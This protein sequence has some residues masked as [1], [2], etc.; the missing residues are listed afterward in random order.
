M[1][2]P[3]DFEGIK[4][5]ALRSARSLLPE[6][7]TGG[8]FEGDEYVVRN[9][10]RDDKTPGSFKIN[11]RTGFWKDF[12]TG[13]GGN[14]L[15]SLVHY[16]DGISQ[17]EAARLFAEKLGIS[18][19]KTN[20]SKGH[21]KEPSP[22]TFSWGEEG[23]RIGRDEVRRHYY[24]NHDTPKLKVKIKK[25]GASKDSWVTCYR[26]IRDGV[27][28]GWQWKKPDDFRVVPYFG[29]TRDPKRSY[30]PE[31][32][33]DADTLDG[34]GLSAF[35]F[36]GVGDGLPPGIEKY[37]ERLKDRQL[38]IPV[39]NDETGRDHAQKKAAL[40]HA[41]GVTH[42]RIFDPKAVWP[43]CP[44]GG[45]VS[46]WFERGG[47]TREKLLEIIDAL[48]DW[49]P[50]D[51]DSESENTDDASPSWDNPDLSL[52]DDRRGE[53]PPFPLNVLSA[54]WQE[55][56]TNAAHGAGTTVDHVLVPL[57]GVASSLVGT[58]R[59]LQ[60][61]TS[62]TQPFTLWIAIVGNSGTGKTPGLNVSQRTLAR[63][64]RNR[65]HLIG[66]L[67]R[68]HETKIENAKVAR[69]QW[70]EKV[71]EAVDAG[72]KVPD[73]PPEAEVPEP[74]EAPRL[75]LSNVTIEK[76]A[77]L[78]QARPQGMLVT[79]DELAG[80]FLNLSRYSGGTDR[81]FWLE[82][83]NGEAY[84]VERMGRPPVDIE[85]LLVG[86]A[87]GLQPD[88]LAR[89]FD[90]DADG[91]YA[92]VLFSWPAE[93]PYRPLTDVVHEM[94]PELE[95]VF[96]RL[97]DLAESEEGKL[98]VRNVT[99]TNDARDVFEAFRRLVHSKKDGLDGRER[100]WWVKT[101]AHVLRLAGTLAYLDWA[102]ETVGTTM[103]E[104]GRIETRFVTAA[105]R[106]VSEYFWPHARAALRQI[107]LT[108]RHTKA[109][110]VLRWLRAERSPGSE[111][112]LKDIR[113]DAL[114]QSLDAEATTKLIE[115]LV[116]AGWLRRVPIE[117]DGRGR[118]PHR[119]SINP[120]LW[121]AENADNA[122]NS[123]FSSGAPTAQ[124]EVSFSALPAFSAPTQ[125][126]DGDHDRKEATWT[127]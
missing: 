54:S 4:V 95:N 7:L 49:Q 83:W 109:R 116:Q 55:W 127:V 111:L 76:L 44:D 47:G 15:I 60:A 68:A 50:T 126:I 62:W 78:L 56:A 113:R 118:T 124:P 30:W 93:A 125:D 10:R 88:K 117:K 40:A 34:P 112:S 48:P 64:E 45:D 12:A 123:P 98:I 23:P 72:R 105:V 74:F 77:V 9:P 17:G 103:P 66:K 96:I 110:K 2:Q 67:R 22:Q 99:L 36:G 61:S 32:E 65:R 29:K 33:K 18:T 8:K 73:M 3:I 53:L 63:V 58:A 91:L 42:I 28:I 35:T 90:G 107:G 71:K 59:R 115:A 24:P 104:P 97:I 94:D 75:F 6:L 37:L 38:V 26:A 52:L 108:E 106:L 27:P 92:R 57:F 85:H 86:L 82:A 69:K 121:G 84:R 19:Y 16:V 1:T 102:R 101:P 46:D 5:A 81:E 89:S 70:Q 114:G 87:G 119:W 11:S 120:L 79:L 31:G 41:A 80:L 13:D 51:D 122:G 14:D 20:G 43:E 25:R 100:E 39:D 21:T